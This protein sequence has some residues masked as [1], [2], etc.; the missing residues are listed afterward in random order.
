M[1]AFDNFMA[2]LLPAEGGY[3]IDA[4][5]PGGE[6][7][8]G[9]SKRA[10]PDVDLKNLTREGAIAI[11][12]IQYWEPI[13]GDDLPPAIA[14]MLADASVNEGIETAVILLQHS[15]GA[16]VDGHLGPVTLAAAQHVDSKALLLEIAAH[17][18]VAYADDPNEA[19]FELGWARRLMSCVAASLTL[20]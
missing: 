16:F 7:N 8:F 10:H 6:T 11:Y 5:D 20:I 19:S 9:I 13:H 1:N 15:V 2:W 3:H 12:R 18:M 4:N 14:F 17:R